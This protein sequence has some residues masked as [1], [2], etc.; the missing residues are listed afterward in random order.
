MHPSPPPGLLRTGDNLA[1]KR[2]QQT[3]GSLCSMQQGGL[4]DVTKHVH[5]TFYL[6][7]RPRRPTDKNAG[8]SYAQPHGV[9]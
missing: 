6:S 8:P 9:I 7:E 5:S 4:A 3:N 1:G 2:V